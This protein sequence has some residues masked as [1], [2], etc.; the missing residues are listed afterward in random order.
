MQLVVVPLIDLMSIQ[1]NALG[2]EHIH[3][4]AGD[5]SS[6]TLVKHQLKWCCSQTSYSEAWRLRIAL[7]AMQASRQNECCQAAIN[8]ECG[9]ILCICILVIITF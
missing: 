2:N 7:V 9:S 3:M 5:L 6:N 1:I 4:C 8:K